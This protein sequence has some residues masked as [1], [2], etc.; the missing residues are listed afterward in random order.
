MTGLPAR[1][2]AGPEWQQS[3]EKKVFRILDEEL[4]RGGWDF[5]QLKRRAILSLAG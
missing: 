1:S 5:D 2:Y 4:Q 3:A